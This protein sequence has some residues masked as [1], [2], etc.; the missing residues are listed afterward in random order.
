MNL[1]PATPHDWFLLACA[2][3]T[4]IF[5]ILLIAK[6]RLHPAL[7]LAL[8]AMGLGVASGM[9]LKQ[10]PLS[11]TGGVGNLMGHIAIVLGLGA[12]L[13]RLVSASGGAAALGKILVDNCG[14]KGLPWAL[15]ALGIL[16]GMPVFFEVGLVLLL[17]IVAAAALRSGRP[18]IF[19]ALP[20]LAGLSIVHA[21]FPPHPAAMLA[22]TQFHADLGRTMLWGMMAGLPAAALAG[23][24]LSWFL[25]R[26][27]RKRKARGEAAEEGSIL[28]ADAELA[29]ETVEAEG[30]L[31]RTVGPGFSPDIN[32]AQSTAALAP[33]VRF[34]EEAR[35]PQVRGPHG[36]VF[37][38]GVEASLLRPGKADS[39]A[40]PAP[41][42]PFRA[43][44]AILLP[45]VLIFLGSWA[46]S[47]SAPGSLLNQILHFT[48][49]AEVALL[50]GVLAALVTLG[51]R[52]QTGQHHGAELLRKL[53]G[54]SFE[55]IAGV[56]VILA[57][58]GGLSGI[59][60]DSGAAQSTVSLALGAHMPPL[61]L[62]WLLAAVVR[63]AM[64]SSTV[65]M[66][67]ASAVLAP[68]AGH[69]GV[70][71][72]LLVLATGTGSIILSHVNDPGFWMIQ[73][74]FKLDLKET[75]STWTVL[76]TILSVA[77]L[78]MTLLLSAVLG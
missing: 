73:S 34:S 59:L 3:G 13:G 56:L 21:V 30:E 69:I 25:T 37:V 76:E 68:M 65:A 2:A 6:V 50:I 75:L 28:F 71:P 44:S 26:Q 35:V 9:P 8:A 70:R 77:G 29:A 22:A 1:A 36:Q 33:E 15:M 39:Y 4:V 58:A 54:E 43:A 40:I 32:A 18:P 49:S 45:V 7:A 31:V 19:V 38:R 66:A 12:V 41:A 67:V 24:A 48:G 10:V 62:A 11:F 23:P 51:S 52:I 27:W 53:T 20:V 55:P 60:R 72:E 63:V 78:G 17:P 61:L 64:G 57:A 47:L 74:F 42:G 5:L 46:D 14:P 16:V